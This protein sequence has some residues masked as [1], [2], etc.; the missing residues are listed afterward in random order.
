MSVQVGFAG[1][2]FGAEYFLAQR[3]QLPRIPDHLMDGAAFL[4]RTKEEAE[5]RAKIGGTAFLVTKEI[6]GSR[7]AFGQKLF[8]PYLVSCRHV[9]FGGGASVVSIN[10]R[11]GGPPDIFEFEPT[12]WTEHPN[13]DDVIAICAQGHMRP[14][15]HR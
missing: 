1:P 7:E 12:D 10:R 13:G 5:R 2:L 6:A 4:F 3:F 8:V 9:V 14:M 15:E 11:D